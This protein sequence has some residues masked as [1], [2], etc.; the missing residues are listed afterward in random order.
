MRIWRYAAS[1][2]L[3][4]ELKEDRQT[5]RM[6]H[7]LLL[8][9][10]QTNKT[11]Y[12][13][14][15]PLL[16]RPTVYD[17]SLLTWP[18]FDRA[19]RNL[20]FGARQQVS[21]L[22]VNLLGVQRPLDGGHRHVPYHEKCPTAWLLSIARMVPYFQHALKS[23][24]FM[25]DTHACRAAQLSLQTRPQTTSPYSVAFDPVDISL[26]QQWSTEDT[27]TLCSALKQDHVESATIRFSGATYNQMKVMT[28]KN[29]LGLGLV[30]QDGPGKSK[31]VVRWSQRWRYNANRL[32]V[33][34]EGA[35]P[36]AH[37]DTS[38]YDGRGIEITEEIKFNLSKMSAE[39]ADMLGIFEGWIFVGK[40]Y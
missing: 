3:M 19:L 5:P 6:V 31:G 10:A 29:A 18:Q 7:W 33:T 36:C 40:T 17:F 22:V 23:V 37:M 38:L 15:R 32:I 8:S 16:S 9:I 30:P 27:A 2:P 34:A 12:E 25:L 14:V 11:I 13:E 26:R 24:T 4:F 28:Q 39:A 1:S 35:V 21:G 20:P